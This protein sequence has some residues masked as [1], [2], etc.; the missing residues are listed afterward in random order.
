MDE[1]GMEN[2]SSALFWGQLGNL[3]ESETNIGFL[4]PKLFGVF[5]ALKHCIIGIDLGG[6]LFVK[7]VQ[8]KTPDSVLGDEITLMLLF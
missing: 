4:C 8:G 6:D 7:L 3:V 1:H 2:E 5:K